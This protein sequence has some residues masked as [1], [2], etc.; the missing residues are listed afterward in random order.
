[1]HAILSTS[2]LIMFNLI[3]FTFGL[4]MHHKDRY[5][6]TRAGNET[7][8]LILLFDLPVP[9]PLHCLLRYLVSIP[10]LTQSFCSSRYLVAYAL[11]WPH[12]LL[13]LRKS[14]CASDPALFFQNSNSC[15]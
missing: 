9:L 13:Y 10:L 11:G 12:L 15:L 5:R 7:A 1:M 8:K 3:H 2:V 14:F 4:R 6:Q